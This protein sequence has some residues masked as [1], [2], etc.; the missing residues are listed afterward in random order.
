MS[1]IEM[2]G[3][4]DASVATAINSGDASAA[5]NCYTDDATL[6]PPGAP[7][8]DGKEAART[9]WQGAIDAGLTNVTITADTVDVLGDNGVSVGSLSGEM[10]GQKLAGKYIVISRRAGDGWKILRDIWNFDA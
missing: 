5:A 6:L 2:I 8:M 10:G 3:A 7:R 4:L 1:D 9:F